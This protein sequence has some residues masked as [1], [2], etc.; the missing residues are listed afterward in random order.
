MR[1]DSTQVYRFLS[2]NAS[3]L[4]AKIRAVARI[5]FT[6][7]FVIK[8]QKLA[9]LRFLGRKKAA[10]A[11]FFVGRAKNDMRYLCAITTT[12]TFSGYCNSIMRMQRFIVIDPQPEIIK[13][14]EL[15]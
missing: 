3:Q 6:V 8:L 5:D 2:K 7:Y 10:E 4:L 15:I 12:D 1:I 9:V 11:A 14:T 13:L